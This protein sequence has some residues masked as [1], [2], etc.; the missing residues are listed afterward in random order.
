[1]TRNL[2][3][4]GLA[5]V[6]IFVMS[7][8]AASAASAADDH[9]TTTKA[10]A[11]LTGVSH[12][13]EFRITGGPAFAC[14]TSKFTGTVLNNATEATIDPEYTGKIN[15]TPHN[16]A[17]LDPRE[18]DATGGDITVDM[19]G[20]HYDLTGNTTG[21]DEGKTD[22]TVWITCPGT[23]VIKITQ[24]NTMV[25]ISIP[26]QTPTVGGVTY[27][28][29]PNHT[30]GKAVTVKATA[31]GITYGCAPAFACFVAGAGTHGNDSDYTGTVTATGWEDKSAAVPLTPITEGAQI[32][33]EVSST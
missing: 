6:A 19:N 4:L 16:K 32:P 27:T 18:C 10:S 9:F 12:D 25:T 24:L 3:A 28:N 1:M 22:A 15:Q 11:L 29:L 21:S 7:A 8:V 26:P 2:K 13:N 20:C 30:G 33:I 17:P 31:T 23:N 14:T 5:L